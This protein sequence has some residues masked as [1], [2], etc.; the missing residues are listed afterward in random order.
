MSDPMIAPYAITMWDF[1]WLERRW[2]GAGYEDWDLVLDE[3]VERGY[4]AVRI[5]AYPHLVSADPT[6]TWEL[7]PMWTQN[8]WGA[9]SI[10][11][12]Q[13]LPALIEFIT[14]ARDRGVA[15]ALSSW[16][17]QDR[18]DVRMKI[19]SA[20]QMAAIWIDTLRV[21]AAA[22]LLDAV[23]YV[24][25]CNEFPMAPYAPFLYGSAAGEAATRADPLIAS[26]MADSIA[27]VRAEF[28]QLRYTYSFAGEYDNWRDQKVD[29][30][31]FLEPHIWMASDDF[32][33]FY[34]RIGWS[35][36][37]FTPDSFDKLVALGRSTYF[38]K[39]HEY[40]SALFDAIDNV[41][42]WS[43]ATGKPVFTTE[44]WAVTDYK[45]WPGLDWDWVLDLNARAVQHVVT[46]G[47]WLGIATSNFCGP[48]F[49]GVWREVDYHRRLTETIK[50]AR[51]DADLVVAASWNRP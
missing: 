49:H 28:P 51:I 37:Q 48:Q 9:Q 13:V 24:D 41:A 29:E 15:V 3:L 5:D 33:D 26:Y 35:W 1:S 40:D 42:A 36:D 30:L 10:I 18:A 16:F 21:L 19:D 31:D 34:E 23:L 20:A 27:L 14:K 38:S 11:R 39:Q 25:L 46:T 44:C 6:A 12:V 45:D 22:E 43:R 32:T 17:R 47:R 2:P 50:S 7:L 4:N 8:T